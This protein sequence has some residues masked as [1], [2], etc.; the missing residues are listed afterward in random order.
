LVAHKRLQ[1]FSPGA[2]TVDA[3]VG[4]YRRGAI[5]V[6]VQQRRRNASRDQLTALAVGVDYSKQD[7]IRAVDP[8]H[9]AHRMTYRGKRVLKSDSRLLSKTVVKCCISARAIAGSSASA[10]AL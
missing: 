6:G 9:P 3:A 2:W 1:C 8:R 4:L 7:L 10:R 5:R